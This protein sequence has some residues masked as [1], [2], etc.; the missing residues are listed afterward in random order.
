MT[1]K[2]A[3]LALDPEHHLLFTKITSH[4]FRS[5]PV[6]ESMVNGVHHALSSRRSRCVYI[7]I[8]T[9]QRGRLLFEAAVRLVQ[10][11]GRGDWRRST[12]GEAVVQFAVGARL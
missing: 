9:G 3:L 10:V 7:R 5:Q 1:P 4:R 8:A 11:V 12:V 2:L 6:R